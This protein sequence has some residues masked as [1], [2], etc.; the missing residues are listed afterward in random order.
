MVQNN[1]TPT[2]KDD[3]QILTFEDLK[4]CIG[5]YVYFSYDFGKYYYAWIK[6]VT[7][8]ELPADCSLYNQ[9]QEEIKKQIR[10]LI[11]Y[12]TYSMIIYKEGRKLQKPKSSNG[13]KVTEEKLSNAQWAARLPTKE[14]MMS[15]INEIRKYRIY[16]NNYNK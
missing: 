3:E 15:Y 12:G 16:G 14:E 13:K 5:K 8:V 2:Y 7:R 4:K 1:D 11:V 10:H 6:K 9:T